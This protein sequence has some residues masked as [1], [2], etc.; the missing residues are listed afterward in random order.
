MTDNHSLKLIHFLSAG[1]D[2]LVQH[3]IF[4]TTNIPV[5]TSSGIHGPP[6]AEW[7]VMNWLVASRKF[8]DTYE[9]Q[10]NHEWGPAMKYM[11]GMSDQVGKKLGILGYGSIGRQS[12]S[13][14]SIHSG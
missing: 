4:K 10:K 8:V 14:N 12:E 7:T 1:I 9:S 2:H 3:P 11:T 5:T 13:T 6:I